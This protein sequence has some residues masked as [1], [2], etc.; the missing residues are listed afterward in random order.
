MLMGS[1]ACVIPGIAVSQGVNRAG[2]FPAQIPSWETSRGTPADLPPPPSLEVA[3]EE[4]DRMRVR[5]ALDVPLRTSEGGFKGAGFQGSPAVSPTLQAELRY[6]PYRYWFGGVTFYRYLLGDRQRPW[7]PDFTY[8]FGYDDWHAD[9]FS[10]T[11][12]NYTGNR[13]FPD[14]SKL[15]GGQPEERTHFRQGQWSAGYKFALP[16][17]L[18]PLLLFNEK[19]QLGCSIN[20]NL[21]PRYTDLA[22]LSTRSGKRSA[23][24]GCRYS[25]PGNWYGNVTLFY[26]PDRSQQQ[27]WDPD[28]TYGF[29]Y[30][31]WHPGTISVQYNN[32]SG[33]RYPWH[34]RSPGQGA[35]RNGSLSVSWSY[36]W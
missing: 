2:M 6:N 16:E 9:T 29:G 11:Y 33:N 26:F 25:T 36:A 21:T 18:R 1:M 12:S 14:R 34:N 8:T 15:S 20:A 27:P 3:P 32:Y 22:S 5:L 17:V 30:F 28:F 35:P 31:D 4:V 7:N 10:L 23:S 19:D 24:L 13:L